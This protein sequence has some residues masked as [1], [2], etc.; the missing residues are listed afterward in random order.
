MWGIDFFVVYFNL[1]ICNYV[2][3]FLN[4]LIRFDSTNRK[5]NKWAFQKKMQIKKV[6]VEH[7][8]RKQD[9]LQFPI[10]YQETKFL[11]IIQD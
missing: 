10:R 11:V 7:K 9:C 2:Y 5:T 1:L 3:G 8:R 4:L 6:F